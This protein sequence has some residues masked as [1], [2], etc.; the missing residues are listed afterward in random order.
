MA[1]RISELGHFKMK[2]RKRVR[3]RGAEYVVEIR[4]RAKPL[5]RSGFVIP[6]GKGLAFEVGTASVTLMNHG[7]F[8]FAHVIVRHR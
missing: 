6:P 5:K 3:R 2:K 8:T 7:V 4:W 1:R